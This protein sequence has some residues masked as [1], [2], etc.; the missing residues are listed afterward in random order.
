MKKT[1]WSKLEKYHFDSILI[2]FSPLDEVSE[3]FG[4]KKFI[5][6]INV[7]GGGG[8]EDL[9]ETTTCLKEEGKKF[10]LEDRWRKKLFV[11]A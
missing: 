5:S 2:F 3:K 6:A 11:K 8:R 9:I 7:G 1:F 4:K 10:S